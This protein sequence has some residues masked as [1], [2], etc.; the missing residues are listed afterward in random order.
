M[1]AKRVEMN[2]RFTTQEKIID[3]LN[4]KNCLIS[5]GLRIGIGNVVEDN[6]ATRVFWTVAGCLQMRHAKDMWPHIVARMERNG[7]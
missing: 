7:G 5:R 6:Q 4:G 1:G 3:R 2:I